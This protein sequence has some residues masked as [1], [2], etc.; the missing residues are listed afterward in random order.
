VATPPNASV[1]GTGYVPIEKM[2]RVGLLL[3]A[4]SIVVWTGILYVIIGLLF[5]IVPL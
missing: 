5:G 3:D 4:L 2:A 1:Y